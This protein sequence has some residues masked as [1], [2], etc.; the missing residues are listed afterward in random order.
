MSIGR[1][2]GNTGIQ[3][4]IVDAKGDLI[5]ATAADS[6]SRL[7][8]GSNNQVL[9]ADSAQATG[10]K[11]GASAAST[12]TTTGD[13]LYASSANTPARLGIG[14]TDQ[15]L[16]VSGGIPA[17]G[18]A[19]AASFVGASVYGSAYQSVTQLTETTLTWNSENYDTDNIH[20]TSTNT[21]RM[22]VPTGKGGKWLVS[23]IIANGQTSGGYIEIYVTINGAAAAFPITSSGG[24]FLR[25]G[26]NVLSKIYDL[27]AG[28]YIRLVAYQ[29]NNGGNINVGGQYSSFQ[30]TYL[31]A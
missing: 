11:W 9:M 2:P 20:S 31:G 6:V 27:A 15:V 12:L 25:Q 29:N 21:D 5:V 23:G 28:D 8:V 7:A 1:V 18:A 19:P 4:S 24:S 22:T 3:P 26:T 10:V 13:I 16:K 14:S 17:W 30:F